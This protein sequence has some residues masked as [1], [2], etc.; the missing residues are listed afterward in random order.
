[1]SQEWNKKNRLLGVDSE[2]G[3]NRT[4]RNAQFS[5][6]AA[7]SVLLEAEGT[8]ATILET[9]Q[10]RW[11][12]MRAVFE[13]SANKP[14]TGAARILMNASQKRPFVSKVAMLMA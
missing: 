1:M 9:R 12:D 11:L 10:F 7:L 4:L 8:V 6:S 13:N 3:K 2:F 5:S 14:S